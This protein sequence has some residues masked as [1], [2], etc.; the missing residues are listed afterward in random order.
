[1]AKIKTKTTKKPL[2]KAEDKAKDPDVNDINR[3]LAAILL[4]QQLHREKPK[5]GGLSD[6]NINESNDKAPK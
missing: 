1:M 4:F 6:V 2:N 5:K 3:K